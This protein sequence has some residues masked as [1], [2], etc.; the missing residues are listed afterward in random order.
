MAWEGK[1]SSESSARSTLKL[2]SVE[3]TRSRY[4]PLMF[5]TVL[6]CVLSQEEARSK[7]TRKMGRLIFVQAIYLATNLEDCCSEIVDRTSRMRY[8]IFHNLEES[9][10]QDNLV[11]GHDCALIIRTY[12][13][14]AFS[15]YSFSFYRLRN[16]SGTN[17]RPI[18]VTLP[19]SDAA[20][21]LLKKCSQDLL[22]D[23]RIHSATIS[24]DRPWK[25]A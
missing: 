9:N 6:I 23:D 14:I 18:N 25:G 15:P 7:I 1:S 19:N 11:K 3:S 8:A 17:P 4:T 22:K 10:S 21:D 16:M 2:G 12:E 24:R 20:R 13:S 5:R